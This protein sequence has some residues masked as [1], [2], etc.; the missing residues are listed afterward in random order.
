VPGQR[1]FGNVPQPGA[2]FNGF[3]GPN[4]TPFF[5]DPNARQQLNLNDNQFNAL[6][7][8]HQD[9]FGRFNQG[10]TGLGN[11]LTEQQRMQQMQQLEAR[12]NQE[13]GQSIDSTFTDPRMRN[14]FNQLST[15]FRG[16]SAFNDPTVRQQ[17]NLTPAQ[18]RQVRRLE[19]AWRQRL[20][21][22]R[23]AGNDNPQLTQ[24]QF[25]ELQMQNMQQLNAVLTPQQQQ[26]WAQLTGEPVNFA[27]QTFFG[28]PTNAGLPTAQQ[29]PGSQG[30]AGNVV[31]PDN[32]ILRGNT[33]QRPAAQ[34]TAGRPNQGASRPQ[35]QNATGSQGQGAAGT[36]N[37]SGTLR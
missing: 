6:N 7:R 20:Q 26:I 35:N 12:F 31:T 8:A 16:A 37:S 18:Q 19:A 25:N 1:Q 21:Q 11:N 5:A 29:V 3:N 13:F 10:A 30:N 34:G 4:Q 33:A 22:L 32:S 2:N 14:R 28:Q 24:E 27:P 15:Q 36:Q 23:R 9:A 17:L